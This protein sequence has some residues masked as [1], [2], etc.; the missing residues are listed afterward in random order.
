[1]S[2]SLKRGLSWVL[3]TLILLPT[4]FLTGASH[5]EGG[6]LPWTTNY[7][8]ALERSKA[9]GKPIILFFTGSD[10]CTWCHR[11]ESEVLNTTSFI[12][13]VK[14][15]YI[16]VE[17][18][19][20]QQTTIAADL[21]AQNKKLQEKYN[22]RGFPTIVIVDGEG[23]K[24]AQTGYEAGGGMAYARHL[25]N[26]VAPHL[27]KFTKQPDQPAKAPA[28]EKVAVEANLEPI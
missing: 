27:A 22:V 28:Q 12:N 26:L 3:I 19:F 8:Q 1:M 16:F 13:S 11:L 6:S 25:D 7:N 15:K 23:Q 20:P 21:K 4:A 5:S 24:V 17:L 9:E 2:N 18:D 14:D 10:W